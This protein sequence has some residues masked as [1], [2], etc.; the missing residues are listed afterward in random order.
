M[1]NNSQLLTR[2]VSYD[3]LI[4]HLKLEKDNNNIYEHRLEDLTLYCYTKHCVYNENWNKWNTQARGLILD[5]KNQRVVATP[6]PKFFNYRERQIKLPSEPFEALDKLDGSLIICYYYRDKWQTSTK[7]NLQSLQAQKAQI[8][9]NQLPTKYLEKETTYLF[10]YV[11]PDN[12]IIV[13]YS[14]EELVLLGA[15]NEKGIELT[16]SEIEC[17]ASQI[18]VSVPQIFPYSNIQEILEVSKLL[19]SDHEGFVIRFERGLRIK[20]KG[21]EYC[22]IQKL[23]NGITP[24]GIWELMKEQA[25]L[26]LIRQEIPEEYWTDFDKIYEQLTQQLKNLIN[27]VETYHLNYQHLSDKELGLK[28]DSLPFIPRSYLFQRRK[29]G[30]DWYDNPKSRAFLFNHFRPKDNQLV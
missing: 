22:R 19:G 11:S 27:E 7:G 5:T 17:I 16:F 13:N 3:Q 26:G 20:F 12:K 30:K 2:Q 1:L 6:F 23:L 28:L 10:E 21:S 29:K 14:K 4:Y 15:Y 24:L 18:G 8:L 25:N 9:L